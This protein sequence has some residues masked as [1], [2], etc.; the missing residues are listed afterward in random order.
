MRTGGPAV[1]VLV[2]EDDAELAQAIGVGLRRT[3]MAVDVAL[4]GVVGLQRVLETDYDVVVLDR[5]LPGVDG[6]TTSS[7]T[8]A[9]TGCGAPDVH[10]T[11]HPRNSVSWS[12]CSR[13]A[14][15]PSPPKSCSSG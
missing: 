14:G 6:T 1:R 12:C 15:E 13:R 9:N 11:F 10:W 3:D 5:D 7:S 8:P 4:D 2:I